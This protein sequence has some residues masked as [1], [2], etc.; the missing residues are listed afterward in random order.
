[1][2]IFAGPNF[3]ASNFGACFFGDFLYNRIIDTDKA[4]TGRSRTEDGFQRAFGWCENA[5]VPVANTSLSCCPKA[6]G[7]TGERPCR[8]RLICK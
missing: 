6:A 5:A 3:K 2:L 8:L 4:V 7:G 1:M